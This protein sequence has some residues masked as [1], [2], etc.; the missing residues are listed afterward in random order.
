MPSFYFTAVRPEN[1]NSN[2]KFYTNAQRIGNRILC[3]GYENGQRFAVKEN[4]A[5]RLFVKANKQTPFKLLNGTPVEPVDFPELRE[6]ATFMKNYKDVEAF[7]IYGQTNF[8]YQYLSEKYKNEIKYSSKQIRIHIWDIETATEGGFPNIETA[9]EAVLLIA[10]YDSYT[11]RITQFGWKPHTPSDEDV[12][13][14][15]CASEREMFMRFMSFHKSNYPDVISGWH[16]NGFDIPYLVRRMRVVLGEEFVRDLSPWG[17]VN[18]REEFED[19]EKVFSEEIIGISC[20]DYLL[21]YK[22]FVLKPRP[23]YKLDYIGEVELSEKKVDHS[24]HATFKDFYTKDWDKFCRYNAH[25]VRLIKKLESKLKL[26]EIMFTVAYLARINYEDVFSPVRT[27]DTIIYNYLKE[28][29]IVIPKEKFGRK[30][31]K[32]A[33]AFVKDPIPGI[34]KWVASFDLQSLYPHLIMQ[35]AISPENIVDFFAVQVDELVDKKVDLSFLKDRNVSLAANG[36]MFKRES[37]MLPELMEKTYSD[38]AAAK[39]KMISIKKQETKTPEDEDQI[40]ALSNLEQALKI[41]LNSAYG[42]VGSAYFRYFDLRMAEA[43]TLSGQ[44]VIKWVARKINE[45]LN[46][47]C[48]TT[49]VE[50]VFYIDTD[51]NYINLEPLVETVCAGKSTEYKINFMDTF[52]EK[53][54]QPLLEKC[55]EELA[56]YTNAYKQRMYMKRESLADIG[57]W[58]ASKK[59]LLNVHNSEGVKYDPPDLKITGLQIIQ[60]STPDVIKPW[61]KDAAKIIFELDETKIHKFVE[62]AELKFKA[63]SPDVIGK[64]VGA[65]NIHEWTHPVTLYKKGQGC[66][67]HVRGSILFNHYIKSLGLTDKYEPIKSGDKVKVLYLKMPN[68]IKEDLISTPGELPPELGLHKY[69]DYDVQFEKVFLDPLETI[70][71]AIKWSSRKTNSMDDLFG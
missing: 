45:Y 5:P 54:M 44:M 13:Y 50:Y 68:P 51:S 3:I 11:G 15:E 25:D 47:V 37:A 14:I 67:Y 61:L 10:I 31:E 69:V 19:D 24:E 38:R 20:I 2:M 6:A 16:S 41:L 40:A 9:N 33:G 58:T 12:T 43:I 18:P 49:G 17:Y 71:K 65:N 48:K 27:W 52:C 57:V 32:F 22:K 39:K 28:R 64:T 23:S 26:L 42:G 34:Y 60:S 70:L 36:W 55:F 4:F 30:K 53:V 66:P 21:L 29:N 8:T 56:D 63:L 35:Y 46:R 1:Y 62:E 59:Y 7:D